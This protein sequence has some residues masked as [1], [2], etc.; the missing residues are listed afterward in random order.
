[1]EDLSL[2]MWEEWGAMPLGTAP[3]AELAGILAGLVP[4][5]VSDGLVCKTSRRF[6]LRRALKL[7]GALDKRLVANGSPKLLIDREAGGTRAKISMIFPDDLFNLLRGFRGKSDIEWTCWLRG[8]WGSCGALYLPKVGY[9][10]MIKVPQ[11]DNTADLLYKLLRARGITFSRRPKDQRIEVMIRDQQKIVDFLGVL[12]LS[13]A[14]IKLENTAIIRSMKNKAN[15]LV[16]CD[17]ANIVKSLEA[18]ENQMR[19]VR[20]IGEM[21]LEDELPMPLREV[22]RARRENPSLSLRELGQVLPHPVSKSTVEYR[23][24]KLE[25][26]FANLLKGDDAHVPGKG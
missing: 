13:N 1:M 7:W 10:L 25:K 4:Q 26:M 24:R 17:S 9:Y 6:V 12:G 2:S 20:L 21:G 3:L 16:N 15:K 22:V 8:L 18:S 23:W 19:L 14:I 11:F 5:K